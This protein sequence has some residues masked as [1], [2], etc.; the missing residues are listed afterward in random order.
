MFIAVQIPGVS[1]GLNVLIPHRMPDV[2]AGR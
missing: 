1:S 2:V